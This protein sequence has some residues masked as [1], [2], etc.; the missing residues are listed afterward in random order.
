[1]IEEN[2]RSDYR[3][4][5][6]KMGK[7]E[8]TL[9]KMLEFG[10]WPSDLPTPYEKQKNETQEDFLKR[11][12][13]KKELDKIR[14]EITDVEKQ[15][16]KA[17]HSLRGLQKEYGDIWD[18]DKLH[19]EVSQEI[20]RESI[21]RRKERKELREE[22]KRK[23]S[24][25]WDKHKSENIVFIGKGYSGG[26]CD[27][28]TSVEKLTLLGLPIIETDRQ[29]AEFLNIDYKTL[30]FLVFHRDVVTT[31]HYHRYTIPKRNGSERVIAAPKPILKQS[32]RIIL[33]SI[34]NKI[35]LDESAHGFVKGKS[36]VTGSKCHN[37]S[38][39]L[40]ITT[41]IK[42]FFPTITFERV[43]GMFKSIG[44]SGYIASL[45]A[46]ICTYC[47]RSEIEINGKIKYV[48]TTSRIL[49]QGSPASPMITNIICRKL[50]K[51]LC[52]LVKE[53]DATYSRY[54][55]DMSFAFH[56][57]RIFAKAGKFLHDA[58]L[59][60]ENEGFEIHPDK[61]HFSRAST[62]QCV[63]GVV[64]NSDEIGVTREWSRRM[65]ACVHRAEIDRNNGKNPSN[66]SQISGMCAWLES[67]NPIRYEKLITAAKKVMKNE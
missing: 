56:D 12:A 33:S 7:K 59:I 31:D 6:T 55:D 23:K 44:Y 47:E 35:P 25:A 18:Y 34:L 62:R 50:D 52:D 24:L 14:L 57:D 39:H 26:L 17:S 45:L 63:T 8:F 2:K 37:T 4:Q 19:K 32:Q 13:L 38:P 65:R 58:A 5:V 46:M 22:E 16:K 28:N 11:E 9:Q 36:V 21:K 60:V 20:M 27:K 15:Y 29:L 66:L 51:H 10:F 53:Y 3:R 1:M 67:V 41:D 42:D 40:L 49:P 30:R 48:A 61:T 54:A 43:R 64:I